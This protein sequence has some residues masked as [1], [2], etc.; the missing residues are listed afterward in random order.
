LLIL[1]YNQLLHEK[2][3]LLRELK[4]ST[5]YKKSSDITAGKNLLKKLNES[6]TLNM[7]KLKLFEEDYFQRKNQINQIKKT[8]DEYTT[9]I[10]KLID[11][12]KQCFNQ[13]NRITIEMTGGKQDSKN[14]IN[15]NIIDS[16]SNLSSAEKIRAFQKK[17]KEIQSEID[18]LKSK[19]SQT[20]LKLEELTPLFEILEEDHQSLLEIINT[21]NKRI[22]ELQT[23]LKNRIKDDK[24]TEI[25]DIDLNDVKSLRSSEEI[26]INIEN[27]DIELNKIILPEH[28][29][30]L[31]NPYDLSLIIKKLTELYEKLHNDSQFV[32]NENQNE[33]SECFK[34]FNKLENSLSNIESIMNKF[35]QEINI[36]SQLRIILSDDQKSFLIRLRFIRR[37]KAQVKF[38]EL[39][40]PEKVFFIITFYISIKLYINKPIIIFS[41]VSILNQYNKAGSI[42]RTIR[43]ILPLFEKDD[44]LSKFNLIFVIANLEL[45]KKIKN[46]NIITIKVS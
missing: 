20:Q 40:T 5:Q 18:I 32:I 2:E 11:Q 19:K 24:S 29:F 28:S 30:N 9:I 10:Q 33:I 13:I 12:K 22:E 6:L 37:D 27:V 16:T 23:E 38:E 39:T 15:I 7:K 43:K 25:L 26:K 21:D 46:L 36:I 44:S 4:L 1:Q 42:Y 31:Q 34:Q 41:N 45:K 35:L 8:L 3:S 14:D 17:A